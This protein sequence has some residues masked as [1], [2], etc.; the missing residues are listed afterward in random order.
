MRSGI[1]IQLSLPL[2][3][4]HT[5]INNQFEDNHFCVDTY[6]VRLSEACV[7]RISDGNIKHLVL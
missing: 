4:P 6:R 3:S 1:Q 2:S 7:S 5:D